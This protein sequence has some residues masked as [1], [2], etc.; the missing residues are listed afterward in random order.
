VEDGG[1]DVAGQAR[2]FLVALVLHAGLELLGLVFRQRRLGND[3][4]RHAQAVGG[5]LAVFVGA[6]VVGRDGGRVFESGRS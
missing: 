4:A 5:D 3:A 2:Q 1:G 6:E